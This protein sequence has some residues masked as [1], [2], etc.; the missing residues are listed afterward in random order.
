MLMVKLLVCVVPNPLPAMAEAVT[1][2]VPIG[3]P[4]PV[5]VVWALHRVFGPRIEQTETAYASDIYFDELILS[6]QGCVKATYDH[7]RCESPGPVGT[8]RYAKVQI[9]VG[10]V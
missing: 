9:E 4:D 1:V 3:V 2:S 7:V 5:V 8:R 10:V 6:S